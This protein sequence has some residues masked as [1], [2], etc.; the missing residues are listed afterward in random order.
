MLLH[1]CQ[2]KQPKSEERGKVK[3]NVRMTYPGIDQVSK[4]FFS[5][6]HQRL[7]RRRTPKRNQKRPTSQAM[8]NVASC[9]AAEVTDV[10]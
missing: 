7:K 2:P 9:S 6:L 3:P 10:L 8:C 1:L 4:F 5:L